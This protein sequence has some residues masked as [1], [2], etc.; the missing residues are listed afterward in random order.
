MKRNGNPARVIK[1]KETLVYINETLVKRYKG[2][3]KNEIKA[4]SKY[5]PTRNKN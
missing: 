1:R 5:Q 2:M 3:G 4:K